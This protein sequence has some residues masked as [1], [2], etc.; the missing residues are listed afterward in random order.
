MPALQD[1]FIREADAYTPG[2]PTEV[3]T[4]AASHSPFLSIPG[5]LAEALATLAR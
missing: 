2:N 4:L 3:I 5:A 1:R